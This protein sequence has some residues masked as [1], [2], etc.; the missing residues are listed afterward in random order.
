MTIYEAIYARLT[1]FAGLAALVGDRVYPNTMPQD[2]TK[3]AVAYRLVT[4]DTPQPQ[5]LVG[6]PD[7]IRARFQFDSYAKKYD[8]A[9]AVRLQIRRALKRWEQTGPPVVQVAFALS[10]VDLYEQDTEL[11]NCSSDFEINYEE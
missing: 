5:Q 4:D 3:P 10:N 8:D 1:G 9:N 11:H 2:T 6:E 7:L